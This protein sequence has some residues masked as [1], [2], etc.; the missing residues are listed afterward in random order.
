MLPCFAERL[1]FLFAELYFLFIIV[2]VCYPI[3]QVFIFLFVQYEVKLIS[4][5]IFAWSHGVSL[6]QDPIEKAEIFNTH[7]VDQTKLAGTDTIPL[8]T[9]RFQTAQTISTVTTTN[10]EV[11]NLVTLLRHVGTTE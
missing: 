9:P 11:F 1:Y 4:L 8:L 3:I 6:E 5:L 7:F 10:E 2:F